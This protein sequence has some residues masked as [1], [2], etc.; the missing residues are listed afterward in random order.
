MVNSKVKMQIESNHYVDPFKSAYNHFEYSN[1][2]NISYV[3]ETD[4]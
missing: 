2:T 4:D 1:C 3:E